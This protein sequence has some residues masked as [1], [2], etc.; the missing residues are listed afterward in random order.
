MTRRSQSCLRG[1]TA[2]STRPAAILFTLIICGFLLG[3]ATAHAQSNIVYN[4]SFEP[5]YDGGWD[6][7]SYLG[8]GVN[9]RSA[10]D[11]GSW[12]NFNGSQDSRNAMLWQDLPTVP[13]R[14]YRIQFFFGGD[15][16]SNA[17]SNAMAIHFGGTVVGSVTNTTYRWI[18]YTNLTGIAVSNT[19]RLTFELLAGYGSLDGVSVGWNDEPPLIQVQPE[20]R[21]AFEGG[22]SGLTVTAGGASPLSYQ[23][24]FNQQPVAD[25]TAR[26]YALTN[27]SQANAGP[28]FV[29][30]TNSGG[31]ITSSVVQ[32]SVQPIPQIPIITYQPRNQTLP[33]GFGVKLAVAA[34]GEAPLSYQWKF[35]GTDL[36]GETNSTLSI[37]AF[38]QT[39]AGPYVVTVSNGHGSDS[40]LPAVLAVT[41]VNGGGEIQVGNRL[42]AGGYQ[43]IYAPV[44]DVDGVTKIGSNYLGQFYVGPDQA[45]LLPLGVPVPFHATPAFVAGC[46]NP[47]TVTVPNV[48][49]GSNAYA[50]FRAWEVAKGA[51]YEQAEF[52]GGK[53]G[54][55]DILSFVTPTD[56]TA[57][58]TP[59]V[60][61]Q[62]FNLLAGIGY[63]VPSKITRGRKLPNGNIEWILTGQENL[64]YVVEKKNPP[65]DW[66]PLIV[67]F[68][69]TGTVTFVD[70]NQS[71]SSATF[72]RARLLD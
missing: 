58:P 11:G 38:G 28:Y 63:F 34:L 22:S 10:P 43:P 67:L 71:N 47:F 6:S 41:N 64:H 30:I 33:E 23:W 40:S 20:S 17:A 32:I 12:M 42:N 57:V 50:Q 59:L 72:Y 39:N 52:G 8:G 60:G 36:S 31:S 19:T 25:G 15:P 68:N 55:S 7:N 70:P 21:G 54:K 37:P 18:Y 48:N 26:T 66:V 29:V 62:S 24:Y 2:I 49:R 35:N 61:L 44:F 51:T 46:I 69:D 4:G 13:G 53:I 14:V 3:L 16:Y 9:E 65:N 27:A 5:G 1:Q 45:S 56:P